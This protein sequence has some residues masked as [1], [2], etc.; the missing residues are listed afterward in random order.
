[1]RS[2]DQ[3]KSP[4][5]N[6]RPPPTSLSPHSRGPMP[7]PPSPHLTTTTLRVPSSQPRGTMTTQH[8]SNQIPQ[9]DTRPYILIGTLTLYVLHGVT[10]GYVNHI[11][12]HFRQ[13]PATPFNDDRPLRCRTL[14]G[15]QYT[16]T[17]GT[18]NSPTVQFRKWIHP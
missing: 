18:P 11:G 1:M 12:R 13:R 2:S 5:N 4:T 3:Q 14:N 7:P 15:P 17:T 10:R 8:P 6:R 16:I 9:T